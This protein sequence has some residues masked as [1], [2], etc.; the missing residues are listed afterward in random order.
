[1]TCNNPHLEYDKGEYDCWLVPMIHRRG[2]LAALPCGSV[3]VDLQAEFGKSGQRV[4]A[5]HMVVLLVIPMLEPAAA[6]AGI[7]EPP[8]PVLMQVTLSTLQKFPPA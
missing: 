4:T 5:V 7:D 8:L 2:R 6:I 3:K 1:M